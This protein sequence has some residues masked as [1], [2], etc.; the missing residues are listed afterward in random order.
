MVVGIGNLLSEPF[1]SFN[2][3]RVGSEI[4]RLCNFNVLCEGNG[5]PRCLAVI[6]TL[7]EIGEMTGT[8]CRPEFDALPSPAT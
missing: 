3:V 6:G 1:L 7:L 5:P 4:K 2:V 8:G